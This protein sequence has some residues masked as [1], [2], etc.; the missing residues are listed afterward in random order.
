MT[1]VTLTG[2]V[3]GVTG[4]VVQTRSR[5]AP[6][7]QLAS[8]TSDPKTGAFNLS[9]R[10]RL[11]TDYRLATAAYA[12]AFVRIR[13]TPRV[14]LSRISRRGVSGRERPRLP[15]AKV[16]VQQRA[17][18]SRKWETVATGVAGKSGHFSVAVSLPA[19]SVRVVVAAGKGWWPGASPVA[20][21]K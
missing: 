12:A 16:L 5:H 20:T 4:A 3:R 18:G 14:L 17:A 6:W 19:G 10:P 2:T 11:T 13:V 7:A 21:V 1:P 8:V 15:G 9:V